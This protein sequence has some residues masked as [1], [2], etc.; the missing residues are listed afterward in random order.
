M[1][2][3]YA[4]L[5]LL[6]LWMMWCCFAGDITIAV[7]ADGSLLSWGTG[8]LGDGKEEKQLSPIQVKGNVMLP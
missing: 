7:R 5:A 3:L 8:W 2:P 4:V 6:G 1:V